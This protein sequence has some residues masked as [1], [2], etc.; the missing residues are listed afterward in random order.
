MPRHPSTHYL[1]ADPVF[2]REAAISSGDGEGATPSLPIIHTQISQIILSIAMALCRRFQP[3][4][5]GS[6]P[7]LC[8]AIAIVIAH[9]QIKLRLCIALLGSKA[10]PF[11][12]LGVPDFD[13]NFEDA[14]LLF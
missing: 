7:I 3:P 10:I 11:H 5:N 4:T 12:C 13:T 14:L 8:H 2:F 6:I 9:A 1:P